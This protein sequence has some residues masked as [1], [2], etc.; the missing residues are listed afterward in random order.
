MKVE[1]PLPT[2]PNSKKWPVIIYHSNGFFAW[3]LNFSILLIRVGGESP[4]G[5]LSQICS[6]ESHPPQNH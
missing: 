1:T 3:Q 6:I 2:S 4:Y 5:N